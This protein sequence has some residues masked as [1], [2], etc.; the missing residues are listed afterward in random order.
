[1]IQ[2]LGSATVGDWMPASVWMQ[3]QLLVDL[4][5][6]RAAQLALVA[7]LQLVPPTIAANLVFAEQLVAT[8]TAQIALGIQLPTLQLQLD[9]AFAVISALDI[10]IALLVQFQVAFGSAGVHGYTYSGP[11]NQFGGELASTLSGGFPGGQPS[12]QA[13]ALVLATTVPAAWAALGVLLRTA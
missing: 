3:V 11:A 9:A 7:S 13:N 2:Y 6:R 4:Q 5:S 10:A 8:I 12:D 1:M